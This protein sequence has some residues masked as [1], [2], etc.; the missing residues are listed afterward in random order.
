MKKSIIGYIPSL[1]GSLL[2][3][4]ALSCAGEA[5]VSAAEQVIPCPATVM[6]GGEFVGKAAEGWTGSGEAGPYAFREAKIINQ[7]MLCT[8]T[9]QPSM[10][11][12]TRPWEAG[13]TCTFAADQKT[14]NC[15]NTAGVNKSYPCLP[16]M[17][18][19][20]KLQT[21]LPEGWQEGG[22]SSPFPF[23]EATPPDPIYKVLR[24][25]YRSPSLTFS[26][27][28]IKPTGLCSFDTAKMSWTCR[29]AAPDIKARPLPN[30]K[31]PIPIIK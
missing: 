21:K 11:F 28:R 2:L 6:V 23:L 27:V 24:C 25:S 30:Q 10:S 29:S 17:M 7:N 15:R 1:I 5:P 31:L 4:F 22:E 18:I 3:F 13:T 14:W 26:L 19:H 20:A 16:S 8:Y 12:L 9:Q